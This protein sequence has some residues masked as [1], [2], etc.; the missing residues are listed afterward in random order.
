MQFWPRPRESWP[1]PLLAS[2]ASLFHIPHPTRYL[3]SPTFGAHHLAPSTPQFE[4]ECP[5]ILS[6]RTTPGSS[7]HIFS[8]YSLLCQCA[9]Y[10]KH[11]SFSGTKPL[12]KLTSQILMITDNKRTQKWGKRTRLKCSVHL[13][14]SDITPLH[15][16]ILHQPHCCCH[17]PHIPGCTLVPTVT[18]TLPA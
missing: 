18:Q 15:C 17:H 16:L 4:G 14:A 2:L 13:L 7:K 1:Q 9:K 5:Q 8:M 10:F 12:L 11:G 3:N 6:S